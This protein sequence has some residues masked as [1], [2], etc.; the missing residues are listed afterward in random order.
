MSSPEA[1]DTEDD[2]G[3]E[4]MN[5]ENGDTSE[6]GAKRRKSKVRSKKSGPKKKGRTFLAIEP[7]PEWQFLNTEESEEPHEL[8][9][10]H[11]NQT[12]SLN[13]GKNNTASKAEEQTSEEWLQNH[14]V[15]ESKLTM[16]D[17]V[18]K[19]KPGK[20]TYDRTTGKVQQHL[21]FDAKDINEFEYRLHMQIE[22]YTKRIKWMLNGSKRMFGLV[23]GN[24]V[25]VVIDSSDANC[26]FGRLSNF[27]EAL[28]H[29]IDEQLSGKQK[30]YLVKFGSD[31]EKCWQHV[32]DINH[33]TLDEA[34][35]FVANLRPSGGCNLLKAMKHI[36]RLQDINQ[37][38]LILG[39]VPDQSS[40]VLTDYILQMGV[41]KHEPLHTVAFDCSNHLTNLTLKT[42]AAESR[43]RYH[44][45]TSTS[46]EQI[47]TGS[48]ISLLLK[49]IKN[50]Q[51]VINKIKEMR[52]G[53]MGDALVSIENEISMEVTQVPQSQ[54]L[55]RPPGHSNPLRIEMPKF[56]AKT[57]EEWLK[58][59]G[60]K[61]KHLDLYQVLS[62]NAYS[63]KEEFIPVIRK[64][65]QSQVHEK[66]MAQFH[67]QD[68]TVRNVHVDLTQMFEYQK[69]LGSTVKVF[70]KRIEWLSSG[71]RKIFGSIVEKNVV[72][73]IDLSL[74]NA[75]Y[76]I[77]IQHSLR[78]LLEQQ[79]SNREY[80]NII[81]FTSRAEMWRPTMVKPT[82]E[83]LQ[84]A[85]RWVLGLQCGGSRNFLE[86][87]RMTVENEEELKHHIEVEGVYL[88]T[89]GVP[90]QPHDVCAQYVEESCSGRGIKLHTALFN[91][92]DYDSAGAIPG[93]YANITKTAES[94]RN[95]A[96]STGG[97]FHW[98][99]ETGV[100]ESDDVQEILAEID[101]AIN[102]SQKCAMLV[103][104]V[105]K[106]Y[107]AKE[108]E[109]YEE[110]LQAL[111]SSVTPSKNKNTLPPPKMNAL[112][113][114][115]LK[116]SESQDES[117]PKALTWRPSSAKDSIAPSPPKG[118]RP[119]SAKDPM[120]KV[121]S[122]YKKTTT[123][124][125]YTD[126]KNGIGVVF[127]RYPN[128]KSVRKEIKLAMIPEKEEIMTTKE[129]LRLYGLSKLKLDLTKLVGSQDCRHVQG[130]VRTLNKIVPAKYCDIFPHVN[131][132][133]TIKHLQLLPHEI[134]EYQEML[135]KVLRRY[136]K[137]LQFLLSGSRRVFGVICHK[138]V[139]ILIDTSGSM[140]QHME[141]LRKE[142]ASLI[143]DQLYKLGA[144]FNLIR[145]SH[146]CEK[147]EE[148]MV[149]ATESA[150]HDAIRWVSKLVAS[151]NTCTLDALDRAFEDEDLEA[152]YL[153]TDGKP[154]HSTSMVL[155]E[156]AK[157][158]TDRHVAVNTISF[159]CTDSTAN[160]FLKMLAAETSGRYHRVH[161][162]FDAHRFAHKLLTE[163]FK[164]AEYPHL[165]EF[166]GDDLRRLGTEIAQARRFLTQARSF[167]ELFKDH[168]TRPHDRSRTSTTTTQPVI[169]GGWVNGAGSSPK[170]SSTMTPT[171]PKSAVQ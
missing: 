108:L 22:H 52:K 114:A 142:L 58:Q 134:L 16:K 32:R 45:Y 39:S 51:D 36:Y 170:L 100:I 107:K 93:R 152:I 37:I 99:R 109:Y 54:F 2:I 48:D 118:N 131:I 82:P 19:G 42:L 169:N 106:K 59:N 112:S 85:W 168:Q 130:E 5:E 10:T 80:F 97:R 148:K 47:Y 69:H 141:E 157:M 126:D 160:N 104:S 67:W 62:P 68:G 162:D 153:L 66:A 91:V 150:C 44:C 14:S 124:Q 123:Q 119:T 76:L 143:W 88:F 149:D 77:H 167:M 94:L 29:L 78:L 17:L 18:A 26:G 73:L 38:V 127:K 34:K 166:D 163:G 102:F 55:P 41:G 4:E 24:K 46:E 159:N 56:L 1:S 57:S 139:A 136:L 117:V 60:L 113:L 116:I 63:F 151:G 20:P 125:F 135:E 81:G 3:D 98:F 25:A 129:W 120:M 92:D 84:S 12:W 43:G 28:I 70:E 121:K 23:K 144:K 103:E 53:M 111:P 96:H 115:R 87:Y 101:R 146:T 137:R 35:D 171:R 90:D 72:L 11:V 71:S 155:R 158:N 156:V 61:A 145:F 86:A 164:E 138:R 140:D 154:D 75:N 15:E 95:L 7:K 30:L 27:Q 50:A 79:I 74:P 165:P 89:S 110:Q 49:E 9:V 21:T 6:P 122:T 147:W 83:N 31:M 133:G 13:K 128:M 40:E 33:R 8:T 65:V 105:K 161:S 132:G 64:T